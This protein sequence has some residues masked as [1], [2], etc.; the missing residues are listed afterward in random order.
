MRVVASDTDCDHCRDRPACTTRRADHARHTLETLAHA[1]HFVFDKTGTLTHG[2][3]ELLDVKVVDVTTVP[4]ISSENNVLRGRQRLNQRPNIRL[5]TLCAM[6]RPTARSCMPREVVNHPGAGVEGCIDGRRMRIGNPAFVAELAGDA[7]SGLLN[8]VDSA[9][10]VALGEAGSDG[11]SGWLAVFSLGDPIRR[12]SARRSFVHCSTAARR[13]AL[14]SGDRPEVVRHVA[15]ELGIPHVIADARPQDKLDYVLRQQAA[16]DA[17]V[18]IGDGVNDAP[19]LAA[20]SVSIA[21]GR[22]TD[23]ARASADAVLLTD[24][25]HGVVEAVDAARRTLT[26]I[27]QNLGW[28][29]AYNFAALPLAALGYVT[30]WMAGV[31]MATQF[32]AG[33][34]ECAAADARPPFL[35]RE[36]RNKSVE[37]L[38]LLIPLSVVL[39]FLIAGVFWWAT[40]NG[41]FDD[42]EG[43][44]HQILMDDET[45]QK[46]KHR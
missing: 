4:P 34:R 6:P 9:S 41:Q 40:R 7:P 26:V 16:G 36:A 11:K 28:A 24:R 38:Y 29:L 39:V 14:L 45:S 8:G 31:G 17:I 3:Y 5:R 35:A 25:L 44:A 27:R 30:P 22:S 21:V 18:M 13:S 2:R 20:A 12:R 32:A 33:G 46:Q 1:T 42:L 43:P 10:L 19:V 37:I 23:V 15:K